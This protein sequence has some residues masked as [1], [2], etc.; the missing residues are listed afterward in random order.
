MLDRPQSVLPFGPVALRVGC[1]LVALVAD[2]HATL[3]GG[4]FRSVKPVLGTLSTLMWCRGR[5]GR[6][7]G[8][9][10]ELRDISTCIP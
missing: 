2:Q 10:L 4:L 1:I 9:M 8:P 3:S 7:S 6:Q 5:L